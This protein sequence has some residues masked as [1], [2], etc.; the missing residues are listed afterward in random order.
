MGQIKLYRKFYQVGII[1]TGGT[2]DQNYVLLNPYSLSANTYVAGIGDTES[3]SIIETGLSI[4][5]ENTGIYYT[6][7]NP[8]LYSSD[9]TYDLIWFVN[10]TNSAPVKKLGTRFRIN[11]NAV[12]NQIEIEYLH[13][14]LEIEISQS[15]NQI[16]LFG[17]Y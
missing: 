5:Q 7:L 1:R 10:Y 14:P 8:T 6:D 16:E 9:V 2:I 3:S 11:V 13:Y 17:K 12:T 15:P 4:T